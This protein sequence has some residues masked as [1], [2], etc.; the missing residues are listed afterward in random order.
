[1]I[2]ITYV[3][4]VAASD[5]PP[6]TRETMTLPIGLHAAP[7]IVA[8]KLPFVRNPPS[9]GSV[10]D[11]LEEPQADDAN[12]IARMESSENRRIA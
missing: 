1:M 3:V 2:V 12:P 7:A 5:K 8:L 6:P 9:D 4:D 11:S 10:V